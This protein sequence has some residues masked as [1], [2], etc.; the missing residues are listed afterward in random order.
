MLFSNNFF[1]KKLV[2]TGHNLSQTDANSTGGESLRHVGHTGTGCYKNHDHA[3]VQPSS[4]R[5]HSPSTQPPGSVWT[6]T[7]TA[8]GPTWSAQVPLTSAGA[9]STTQSLNL[10]SFHSVSI[11][12]QLIYSING[13]HLVGEGAS[14]NHNRFVD[15][16][17]SS[18]LTP[19]SEAAN[20]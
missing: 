1:W 7:T 15:T 12:T 13:C 20:F 3:M 4:R 9:T 17:R 8:S 11:Q 18:F 10:G 19:V 2:S 14:D 16:T 6:P 5:R